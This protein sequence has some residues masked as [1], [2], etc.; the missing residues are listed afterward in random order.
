M[1]I[2]IFLLALTIASVSCCVWVNFIKEENTAFIDQLTKVYNR[3]Y[4]EKIEELELSGNKYYIV[5]ADIDHFKKVNDNYGH[6]SGDIA[7]KE[8]SR[9]LKQSVKNNTD[10]VIRW[11]G[12]EFVLFL[13]V[14]DS[15]IFTKE[16]LYCRIDSLRESISKT[17]INI[18]SNKQI[19][20]TASFGLSADLDKAIEERI[21]LADKN[22]Y[23]AKESGR[24]KVII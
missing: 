5:F 21:R 3:H 19:G 4:L 10:Y 13:K 12:E 2:D 6:N 8:F 9:I 1:D 22:L 15:E 14:S 11:G 17:I 23:K 20:I 18:S 16:R 7:L 24:N